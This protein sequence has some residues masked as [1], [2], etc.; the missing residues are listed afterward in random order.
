MKAQPADRSRIKENTLGFACVRSDRGDCELKP[1]VRPEIM[2][3]LNVCFKQI[4]EIIL[5]IKMHPYSIL[6]KVRGDHPTVLYK[7]L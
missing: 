6:P 2:T 1:F 7:V 5:W 3:V 4:P